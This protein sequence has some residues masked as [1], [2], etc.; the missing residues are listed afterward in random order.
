MNDLSNKK[1]KILVVD[2][3]DQNRDILRLRLEQAGYEVAEAVDG[4]EGLQKAVHGDFSLVIMDGMMPRKDG[5]QSCKTLKQHA[6]TARLPVIL[7][8]ARLQAIDEMRGWESG[9]DEYLTK[10]VDAPVLIETVRRLLEVSAP[11]EEDRHVS[12]KNS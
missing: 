4:E 11:Q 9:A 3:D 8:T 12:D 1:M 6:A 10:P 5:W 7:L 2:D